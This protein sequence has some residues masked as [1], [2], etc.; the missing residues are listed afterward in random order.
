MSISEEEKHIVGYPAERLLEAWFLKN[1]Y[2][3]VDR[4]KGATGIVAVEDG[5]GKQRIFSQKRD[6]FGCIDLIAMSDDK[7]WFAQV[8]SKAGV[9]ARRRKIEKRKWPSRLMAYRYVRV[10]IFTHSMK[11]SSDDK[12]RY[13]HTW[14]IEDFIPGINNWYWSDPVEINF[15]IKDLEVEKRAI[16]DEDKAEAERI[17]GLPPVEKAAAIKALRKSRKAKKK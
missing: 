3:E 2:P 16:S 1:G 6:I 7:I 8:T 12:R 14:H 11:Q 17:V 13:V 9:S 10:S 5:E 15:D 4:R